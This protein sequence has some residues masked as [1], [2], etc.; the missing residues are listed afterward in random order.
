MKAGYDPALTSY[1]FFHGIE[2]TAVAV[3]LCYA[4]EQTTGAILDASLLTRSSLQT[5]V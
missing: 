1:D 2:H 5:T 4:A 3:G